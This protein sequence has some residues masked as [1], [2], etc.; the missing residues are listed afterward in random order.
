LPVGSDLV[1][2][3]GL[4][5]Q[6][7]LDVVACRNVDL[8]VPAEA[9][10]VLE[11]FCD[12]AEPSI[13]TEPRI[14]PSGH[15][16][17]PRLAAVMQVTA[18]THRA[19]P[20]YAAVAPG[21]PPNEFVTVARAM[22]A[23]FRPLVRLAMPEL[24][25]YDLPAFGGARHWAAVSIRKTYPGQGF[26]AAHAAWNLPAMTFAKML[27][28]VDADVDLSNPRDVPAAIAANMRAGRDVLIEQGPADPFDPAQTLGALGTKMAIDA[29]RKLPGE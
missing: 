8:H 28:V 16:T 1:A 9:E 2:V 12:P 3:A 10:M 21:R 26:R 20:I 15:W 17:T 27:V 19:N 25:D 24:V 7:A 6:K 5:R 22:Q 18:M 29:T 4:L 14:G 23:V 11:G 13:M